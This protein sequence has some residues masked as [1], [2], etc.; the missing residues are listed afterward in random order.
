MAE[1]RKEDLVELYEAFS[2][3]ELEE[4]LDLCICLCSCMCTNVTSTVSMG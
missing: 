2:M 3:E 1:S 4:R